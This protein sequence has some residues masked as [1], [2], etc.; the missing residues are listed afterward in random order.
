MK[1]KIIFLS[2]YL[3]LSA[4]YAYAAIYKTMPDK[5]QVSFVAKGR[6]ALISIKGEGQGLTSLLT[7]NERALSGKIIFELAS[8]KT[9]ID[10]RDEH[11]KNKY[12]EVSKH[13]KAT[14]ILKDLK[15]PD[16]IQKPF[17]FSATL[18][19]HGVEQLITGTAQLKG[20][21]N[22]QNLTAN[23]KIKLSQFQID[24]PSFQ[25]ITV[26]EEVLVNVD[27]PVEQEE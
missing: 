20:N 12:L 14:L 19:L 3:S 16:D 17:E 25:G 6:P 7:T 15:L 2:G 26:A 5:G 11:L 4:H 8:L 13:P 18:D 10:L 24:I 9:G 21:K 23:F 27:V 22:P 1:I